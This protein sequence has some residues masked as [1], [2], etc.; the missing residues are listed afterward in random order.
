MGPDG[1][2]ENAFIE[3]A[4]ADV[5]NNRC[6]VT[7][8]GTDPSQ[9]TGPGAEFVKKYKEKFQTEPEAYAVYGYE[10]AKI[11]LEKIKEVGKKDREAIVKAVLGTKDFDKGALGKWSFDENGDISL[12]K[13]T[14]SKV[15]D[16]K[17]KPVKSIDFKK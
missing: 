2:Y 7:I 3:S 9:L 6:Y 15:V 13:L 14:I 4:G 11:V 16:G 5:L 10:A 8:G 12:Q 17:F 1:C